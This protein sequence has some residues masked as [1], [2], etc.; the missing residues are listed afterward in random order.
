MS[1]RRE[2]LLS[3]PIAA[4]APAMPPDRAKLPKR[5]WREPAASVW[6]RRRVQGVY[7][8]LL[9]NSFT[10][11]W[12]PRRWQRPALGYFVGVLAQICAVLLTTVLD[13]VLPDFM[14]PGLLA[15]FTIVLVALTFGAGPSL[16]ATLAAAILI[17]YFLLPP[18][19]AFGPPH[20]ADVIGLALLSAVGITISVVASRVEGQRRKAQE[21]AQEREAMLEAMPDMFVVCDEMGRVVQANA[22]ARELF[23]PN[24]FDDDLRDSA[25]QRVARLAMRDLHGQPIAR[26]QWPVIRVLRGETLKGPTSQD[27]QVRALTGRELLLNISGAPVRDRGGRLVGA[28]LVLRD[29]TA[30]HQLEEAVRAS[31]RRTH[32]TLNALLAIAEVLVSTEAD[33]AAGTE[34]YSAAPI[35][36]RLAEL[37]CSVLGCRRVAI[38]AVDPQTDIMHSVA[39]AGLSPEHERRWWAQQQTAGRI[40]DWPY[41]QLAARLRTGE[42]VTFDMT[43][44]P[45][46]RRPNPYAIHDILIAPMRMG[47]RLVGLVT[48]DHGGAAH[49]YTAEEIALAAA[50]AKL[51]GLIVERERLLQQREE[52][53]GRAFALHDANQRM[54]DFL[55]V[56]SHELKTPVTSLKVNVQLA[57]RWLAK[58]ART[59]SGLDPRLAREI[60]PIRDLLDRSDR[61]M[62][63]L[64]RLIDDLLD[65]SRIRAGKLELRREPCDLVAIVRDAV[66]EQRAV[67]AEIS[68]EREIA[69]SLPDRET[70]PVNADA[71]RIGQVL[72]NYLTNALKYSPQ[73]EPVAVRV[74]VHDE[75]REGGGARV[76][77]VSVQDYGPGL[78][79]EELEQIWEPFH[80]AESI[81]VQSGSGVGLGLGLFISKTIVERHGGHVG[82][83]TAPGRGST[84]WFTLPL[85]DAGALAGK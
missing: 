79:A 36:Q 33:E 32:E 31:A 43:Q 42:V 69:L 45:Y 72:T 58:L 81:T 35:A 29:V 82:V 65:V 25:T 64:T 71:D 49:T 27:V 12:L 4:P 75:M 73:T 16:V 3:Q 46:N 19:S 62:V 15:V 80:R 57:A 1:T 48:V 41:Q 78:P 14:F 39:V 52:A 28:A 10:P 20:P 84:F 68:A 9:A 5:S 66:Q 50:V 55:G 76:A 51:V 47:E 7:R 53:R 13:R 59:A 44:P 74:A 83:E 6:L 40:A 61:T 17:D 67:A 21:L 11:A 30:Q 63:R 38:L 37:T 34:T 56:A 54:N 26:E 24:G 23:G 70:V 18:L 8:W 22:A 2:D 77:R 60:E 85:L